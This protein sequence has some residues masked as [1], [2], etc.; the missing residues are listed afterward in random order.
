MY[1]V[2][3]PLTVNWTIPATIYTIDRASFDIIIKPPAGNVSYQNSAI[4]VEDYIAPT[5]NTNG[6]VTFQFTPDSTGLWVIA[7]TDG[8]EDL[9]T[10]YYDYKLQINDYDRLTLRKAKL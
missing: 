10:F 2:N 9:N 4:A 7:L 1:L 3:T 6:I 5:I 8:T